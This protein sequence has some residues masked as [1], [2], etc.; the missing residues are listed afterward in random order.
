MHDIVFVSIIVAFFGLA[1]L[2]VHACERIIG[3]DDHAMAPT[4]GAPA[5]ESELAA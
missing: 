5:P 2:L 4:T 3:A 1:W